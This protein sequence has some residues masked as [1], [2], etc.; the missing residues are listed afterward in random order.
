MWTIT[1]AKFFN[2]FFFLQFFFFFGRGGWNSRVSYK[3]VFLFILSAVSSFNDS[4]VYKMLSTVNRLNLSWLIH[5]FFW[6][7]WI[8]CNQLV[9]FM[10]QSDTD[11]KCSIGFANVLL[12]KI[13][14]FYLF[15]FVNLLFW[16]MWSNFAAIT[17]NRFLTM[18]IDRAN[19][20]VCAKVMRIS[21]NEET[22]TDIF[23]IV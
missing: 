3:F 21:N 18:S 16:S 13:L 19:V 7:Q 11:A 10:F 15:F 4:K 12:G 17:N 1:D 6:Y 20:Q 22:M 14:V 5:L 8:C 23:A 2:K 9:A